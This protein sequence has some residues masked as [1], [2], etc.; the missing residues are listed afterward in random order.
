MRLCAA[1]R[2]LRTGRCALTSARCGTRRT[3]RFGHVQATANL[4]LDAFDSV[5][6]AQL[7]QRDAEPIRNGDQGAAVGAS[8]TTRPSIPAMLLL[9]PS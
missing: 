2:A 1:S 3:R 9:S 5:P 6:A 4:H 7:I 8:G